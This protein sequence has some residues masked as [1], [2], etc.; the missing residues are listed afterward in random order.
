MLA[1]RS[2]LY[3]PDYLVNAGGIINVA[4]EHLGWTQN[5]VSHGVAAIAPRL[6]EVLSHARDSGLLPHQ[7]AEAVALSRIEAVGGR[8]AHPE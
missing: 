4:G 3:A 7:A 8:H 1:D 6:L 5:A 2:I